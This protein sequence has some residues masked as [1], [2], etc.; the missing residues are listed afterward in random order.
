MDRRRRRERDERGV[1]TV[2]V[3]IAFPIVMTLLLLIVQLGIAAHARS[4]AEAAAQEGA[5][6]ARRYDGSAGAGKTRTNEYL[7]ELG[8]TILQNRGVS[9]ERGA[10]TVTVTVTGNV[11][12]VIPGMHLKVR[13]TASGPVERYV[14]PEQ[15]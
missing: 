11:I 1:S 7:N 6:V 3:V 14:P 9:V 13:K 2:E 8:P 15:R 5:A 10:E 12:S 4:V